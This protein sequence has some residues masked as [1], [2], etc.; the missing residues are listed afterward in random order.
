MNC[1]IEVEITTFA[2]FLIQGVPM[3]PLGSFD[4]LW[5]GLRVVTLEA[6]GRIRKWKVVSWFFFGT[7]FW[8]RWRARCKITRIYP[9]I[10]W[11]EKE[12][13]KAK[14]NG[15]W[16]FKEGLERRVVRVPPMALMIG[17]PSSSGRGHN[18]G[19]MGRWKER[20]WRMVLTNTSN[21]NNKCD[22]IIINMT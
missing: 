9:N 18:G 17:H 10:V 13:V 7:S 15:W 22:K 11:I 1:K 19:G 6:G 12:K 21:K 8:S 5:N 16:L 2:S 4:S 14:R 20:E 3:I